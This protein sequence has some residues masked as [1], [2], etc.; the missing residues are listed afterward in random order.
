MGSRS[1]FFCEFVSPAE[2]GAEKLDA[3][4]AARTVP[5]QPIKIFLFALTDLSD[6]KSELD[7]PTKPKDQGAQ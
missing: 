1:G 3:A 7:S 6:L 4:P 5:V 2:P